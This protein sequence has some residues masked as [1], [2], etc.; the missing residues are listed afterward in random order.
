VATTG[1]PI[2]LDSR[3]D[4]GPSFTERNRPRRFSQLVGIEDLRE[5]LSREAL[6]RSGRSVLIQGPPGSGVTTLG[7]IYAASLL[8]PRGVGEPCLE[9]DCTDCADCLSRSHFNWFNPTKGDFDNEAALIR[10]IRADVTSETRGGG[11]KVVT[12]DQP[13]WLSERTFNALHEVMDRPPARTTFILCTNAVA[14]IPARTQAVFQPV[15]V[16]R[17]TFW[18]RRGVLERLCAAENLDVQPEVVELMARMAGPSLKAT[19]RDFERLTATGALTQERVVDFYA[20]KEAR[21]VEQYLWAVLNGEPFSAQ[22]KPFEEWN[23][24]ASEKVR[25]VE[26]LLGQL[27]GAGILKQPENLGF[28]RLRFEAWGSIIEAAH[29]AA[30]RLQLR[31]PTFWRSVLRLW[32]PREIETDASFLVRVSEFDELLNGPGGPHHAVQG[33]RLLTRRRQPAPEEPDAAG[34]RKVSASQR[35]RATSAD[36]LTLAE[37]RSIIDAASDMVQAYGVCFDVAITISWS[38]LGVRDRTIVGPKVTRLLHE[39]RPIVRRA[40]ATPQRPEPFHYCYVHESLP[41]EEMC[42]RIIASIPI[43]TRGL[44]GWLLRYL[45]RDLGMTIP[46]SAVSV[47]RSRSPK[48]QD[49]AYHTDLVRGLCRGIEPGLRASTA[50]RAGGLVR[51]LLADVLRIPELE[52]RAIGSWVNA[53]RCRSS[54]LIERVSLA[55]AERDLSLL[56]IFDGEND[57]AFGSGWEFPEHAYRQTW[58][59]ARAELKALLNADWPIDADPLK[60]ARREAELSKLDQEWSRGRHVRE[61]GRPGVRATAP[62]VR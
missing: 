43:R 15:V 42:T 50:G 1:Q 46:P 10:A 49:I 31:P 17:A 14:D 35:T 27:L 8:C 60:M 40:S 21:V 41:C 3:D 23:G 32:S 34:D 53:Y 6:A 52:R 56:S 33:K 28:S 12:I 29:A 7:E 24:T 2:W 11:W 51:P 55:E 48:G 30:V 38:A 5:Y 37:V 16:P 18:M 44:P 36:Y 39:L 4:C 62:P 59:A 57:A 45:E 54:R 47:E 61:G 58:I 25:E 19:L 9:E 13:Q 26:Q 20:Q 22:V